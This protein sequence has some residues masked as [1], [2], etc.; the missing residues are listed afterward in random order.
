[1]PA[2]VFVWGS[3]KGSTTGRAQQHSLACTA[4]KLHN[5]VQA[6]YLKLEKRMQACDA[7]QMHVHIYICMPQ[8]NKPTVVSQ[9]A[10][11]M[12]STSTSA[13]RAA[14]WATWC[15]EC[16]KTN[17]A[18]VPTPACSS[19]YPK[20]HN[21]PPVSGMVPSASNL[22]KLCVPYTPYTPQAARAATTTTATTSSSPPPRH[23]RRA[24]PTLHAHMASTPS[25]PSPFLLCPHPPASAPPPQLITQPQPWPS[26]S[27]SSSSSS[28]SEG[29]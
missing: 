12:R 26:P 5:W 21:L 24:V 11:S 22:S 10:L 19:D 1:M 14:R 9:A 25:C 23:T 20:Q 7:R 17:A 16:R 2:K 27:R 15:T 29:S 4:C 28:A 18:C 6:A 3:T 13:N 8:R